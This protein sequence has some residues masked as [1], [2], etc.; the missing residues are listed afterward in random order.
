MK[1]DFYEENKINDYARH[2]GYDLAFCFQL[3]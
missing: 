1:E 3:L 2:S